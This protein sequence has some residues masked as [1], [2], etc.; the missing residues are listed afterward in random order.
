MKKGQITLFIIVGIVL[1]A[2][3]F[4]VYFIALQKPPTEKE[5]IEITSLEDEVVALEMYVQEC[6]DDTLLVAMNAFG[7]QFALLDANWT[8]SIYG[9]PLFYADGEKEI[10]SLASVQKDMEN[11]MEEQIVV[12][13]ERYIPTFADSLDLG[14][15]FVA[16]EFEDKTTVVTSVDA[17]LL[18]EN[19]SISL[20][21]DLT[22]LQ[23]GSIKNYLAVADLFVSDYID[24][25][26]ALC[27]ACLVDYNEDYGVTFSI[28]PAG[29][30]QL[31]ILKDENYLFEGVPYEF[32]FGVENFA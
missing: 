20:A 18:A 3:V 19:K 15:I 31:V 16:L 24:N 9:P 5:L 7:R 14:R 29:D 26:G 27:T 8:Y 28:V 13:I 17:T 1:V 4:L 23:N 6:S 30:E 10:P 32:R 25:E 11:F 22:S 21:N 2:I 12:C